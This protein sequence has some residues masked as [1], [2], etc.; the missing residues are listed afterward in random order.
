MTS[1]LPAA[2]CESKQYFRQCFSITATQCEETALS[3]TRIC[4]NKY[5]SDLPD[6][7][8]QPKDGTHWGSIV[9]RC[10]GET[11]ETVLIKKRINS[12]KCNDPGNWM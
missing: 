1:A 5:K 11:Y 10:A 2:F 7:L 6:V 9:G 12:Q 8:V 3:V 4:L